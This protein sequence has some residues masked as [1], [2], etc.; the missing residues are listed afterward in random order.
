METRLVVGGLG[1][2]EEREMH[3]KRSQTFP[4]WFLAPPYWSEMGHVTLASREAV[5][6]GFLA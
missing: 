2:K 3:A 4:S 6:C 1:M 5:M